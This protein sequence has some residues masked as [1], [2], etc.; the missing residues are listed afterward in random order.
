[1]LDMTSFDVILGMNWLTSYRETIDYFQHRV[2]FCTPKGYRFQFVGDW[3]YG[4]IPSPT[5]MH[6]LR[7]LNF[8]FLACLVDED[9][10]L[11]CFCHQLFVSSRMSF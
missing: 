9:S 2:T 1:M 7:E 5:V 10:G 6:I 11:V 4:F 3:D 8:I